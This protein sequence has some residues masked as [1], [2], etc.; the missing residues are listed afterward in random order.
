MRGDRPCGLCDAVVTK[1]DVCA[2]TVVLFRSVV[3]CPKCAVPVARL[4]KETLLFAASF[5]RS[6]SYSCSRC[7]APISPNELENAKFTRWNGALYC[8]LCS[9]NLKEIFTPSVKAP[10]ADEGVDICSSCSGL[11]SSRDMESGS[12]LVADGETYCKKCRTDASTPSRSKLRAAPAPLP[13]VAERTQELHLSLLPESDEQPVAAPV[14]PARAQDLDLALL[15]DSDDRPALAAK[16]AVKTAKVAKPVKKPA[17]QDPSEPSEPEGLS[18]GADEGDYEGDSSAEQF[19]E[20]DDATASRRESAASADKTRI[21]N[22][23]KRTKTDRVDMNVDKAD[24]TLT[25]DSDVPD[26]DRGAAPVAKKSATPPARKSNPPEAKKSNPPEAPAKKSQG[27]NKKSDGP[28]L[29]VEEFSLESPSPDHREAAH[30]ET[31]PVDYSKKSDAKTVNESKKGSKRI[32]RRSG[33]G[34]KGAKCPICAKATGDSSLAFAD[35]SYCSACSVEL[36]LVLA[37]TKAKSGSEQSCASCEKPVGGADALVFT[38]SNIAYCG[39]CAPQAEPIVESM[40][41]DG[42]ERRRRR[43]RKPLVAVAA[44]ALVAIVGGVF[45]FTQAEPAQGPGPKAGMVAPAATET[46]E[47]GV[48]ENDGPPKALLDAFEQDLGR[49]VSGGSGLAESAL[50][51]EMVG[52]RDRASDR[53]RVVTT[54]PHPNNGS[55]KVRALME[56]S[57]NDGKLERRMIRWLDET[58]GSFEKNS[59][60]A[61]ADKVLSF[62]IQW[63]RGTEFVEPTTDTMSG[64]EFAKK[65]PPRAIRAVLIT[66]GADGKKARHEREVTLTKGA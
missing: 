55:G 39:A 41:R 37:K 8:G 13:A 20:L 65:A 24:L 40:V 66:Q 28:S 48:D 58:G 31:A 12:A 63:T 64:A 25:D 9:S 32:A 34:V 16:V 47:S 56:Y 5:D 23:R 26:L 50:S 27:A 17:V 14:A 7:P 53:L 10:V 54:V 42:M 30:R 38:L 2:E 45:S 52:P 62:R 43:A 19:V 15:D 11:I 46:A 18:Y 60:L 49:M 22:V 61:L 51:F 35:K 4:R 44:V 36:A 33:S 1:A 57:V 59:P 29:V 6:G 3:Y 21:V